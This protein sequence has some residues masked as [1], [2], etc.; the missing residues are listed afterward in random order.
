MSSLVSGSSKGFEGSH[1]L[2]IDEFEE[3]PEA[4]VGVVEMD[5]VLMISL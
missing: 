3:E 5:I 1:L 2:M 4:G